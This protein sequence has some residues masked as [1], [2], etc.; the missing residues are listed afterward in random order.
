MGIFSGD[1]ASR[2]KRHGV[3]NV[4]NVNVSV[5]EMSKSAKCSDKTETLC[6][7][8]ESVE[9]ASDFDVSETNG[10]SEEFSADLMGKELTREDPGFGTG[11]N[12]P[13]PPKFLRGEGFK[14]KYTL[15]VPEE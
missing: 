2:G 1:V 4:S 11:P 9:S 13:P 14:R 8:Q 6:F 10:L 5:C 15:C 3:T 7:F 12:P